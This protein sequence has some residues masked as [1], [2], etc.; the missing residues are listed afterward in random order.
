MDILG[1]IFPRGKPTTLHLPARSNVKEITIGPEEALQITHTETGEK[2][3]LVKPSTSS[4]GRV[5]LTV[6]YDDDKVQ[7][8]DYFIT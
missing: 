4:F 3:Y 5:S 7:K 1:F 8:I 2:M 6:R